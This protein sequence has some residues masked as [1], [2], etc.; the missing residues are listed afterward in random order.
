LHVAE[1][2]MAHDA[3]AAHS[4]DELGISETNAARPVQAAVASAGSFA[5]GAAL[6]LGIAL[7]APVSSAIVAVSAS[8]LAFLGLLGVVG[9]TTGGANMFGTYV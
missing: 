4:R 9:A 6:P 2:L 1:Q 3:L 5:V 8:S 7:I